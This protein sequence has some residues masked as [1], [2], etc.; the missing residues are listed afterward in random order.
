[1]FAAAASAG[2]SAYII[3]GPP[4]GS[5]NLG[6]RFG[7]GRRGP[8][9]TNEYP[10]C[11]IY[12][13]AGK[14]N[15]STID[16]A[17]RPHQFCDHAESRSDSSRCRRRVT[18]AWIANAQVI[19]CRDRRGH[20]NSASQPG[21]YRPSRKTTFPPC[22]GVSPPIEEQARHDCGRACSAAHGVPHS[23]SPVVYRGLGPD[24]FDKLHPQC[25]KN[26]LVKRLDQLQTGPTSGARSG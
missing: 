22:S 23:E 10:G 5:G 17:N 9:W 20:S 7:H 4:V 18:Y 13:P 6:D 12:A 21:R 15:V 19:C 25:L 24:Y 2:T 26:R 1:M 8:D 11:S 3:A 16:L 14:S